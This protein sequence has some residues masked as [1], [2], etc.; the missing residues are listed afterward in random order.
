[1]ARNWKPWWLW[2]WGG[3]SVVLIVLAFLL[4]FKRWAVAAVIGFGS[5]E[6]IGLVHPSDAYPP[7]TQVVREYV[8]RE[9]AL[10][11]MYGFTAAAGAVWLGFAHPAWLGLLFAFVGWLTTHFDVA[12]DRKLGEDVDRLRALGR[13]AA[14]PLARVRRSLFR[15]PN[16]KRA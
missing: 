15:N 14:S 10:A 6:T 9:I 5:M 7:L 12:Y 13:L 16:R 11:L 2:L 4:P 8:P 3:V 1:M